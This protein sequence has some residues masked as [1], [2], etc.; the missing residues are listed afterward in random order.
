MVVTSQAVDDS[1]EAAGR[2]Q[3]QRTTSPLGEIDARKHL[4]STDI[5]DNVMDGGS[6]GGVIDLLGAVSRGSRTL[7]QCLRW[8]VIPI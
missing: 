7:P 8:L 1:A 6:G 2:P 5:R 3:V 4:F